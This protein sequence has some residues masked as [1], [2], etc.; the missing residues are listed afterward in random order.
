MSVNWLIFK[1][2]LQL[3][4]DLGQH[5]AVVLHTANQILLQGHSYTPP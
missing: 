1:Y 3:T 5:L 4:A 2:F